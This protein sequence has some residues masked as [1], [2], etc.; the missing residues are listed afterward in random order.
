MTKNLS[1]PANHSVIVIG[2]L[3]ML[4]P[5]TPAGVKSSW[6]FGLHSVRKKLIVDQAIPV[7]NRQVS[8]LISM[9]AVSC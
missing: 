2:L 4:T 8:S 7:Q 3:G 5:S 9:D 6:F 1:A